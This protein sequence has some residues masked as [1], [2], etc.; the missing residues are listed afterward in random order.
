MSHNEEFPAMHIFGQEAWHDDVFIV[1]TPS[2]LINLSRAIE[3]ALHSYHGKMES[4][5]S[6]GE[7]YG[8]H[9]FKVRTLDGVSMPYFAEYADYDDE[10]DVSPQRLLK[11]R[12]TRFCS[13]W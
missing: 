1:G 4:M 7:G 2:Q 10:N 5:A 9:V 11:D 6:D 8:I 3:E 13:I 12:E